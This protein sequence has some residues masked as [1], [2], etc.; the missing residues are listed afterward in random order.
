MNRKII[1]NVQIKKLSLL[2]AKQCLPSFIYKPLKDS[3]KMKIS[4]KL[5]VLV[6][7]LSV[8]FLTSCVETVVVG[9]FATATVAVREKSLN[10]TRHDIQIYTILS[11]DFLQ[12]GLTN[13]GNSV[14]I[15]VNEGRVL[16]TGIIRDQ[17][18]AKLA[19][20]LAWKVS[21]VREV[22]DEI[23]LREDE[24]VNFR[25]VASASYDYVITS[26]VE[27]Y[28]LF[29]KKVS[30]VNYKVTTVNKTVYLIG[31][32]QD[33]IELNRVIQIVAKLRGVEKV[34]SHVVLANDRRRNG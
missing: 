8:T 30:S 34:V 11:A 26:K 4:K 13:F 23:Q 32:A 18:K 12:N 21:G 29:S 17:S 16:L 2:T 1:C 9:S 6:S 33:E 31:V 20:E 3:Q 19:Y 22:I 14:D 7:L 5:L 28:L 10:N 15:T 25:D 24:S 27:A